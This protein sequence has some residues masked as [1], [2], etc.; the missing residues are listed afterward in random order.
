MISRFKRLSIATQA[1]YFLVTMLLGTMSA[2]Y[3]WAKDNAL[4]SE[5]S[6]SR[7]V[8]DMADAFRAQ[9]AKHG[10]F[11]V[12]RDSSEDIAKV[13]KYLASYEVE[14]T[15]IDG[16]KKN[17]MFHQKNP[18]L[19]LGD[20]SEEVQ[21][22]KA[23]AQ[24]RM[25]SDNF[26]NPKNKPDAFEESALAALRA[27]DGNSEYWGV[28]NGQ[29]RYTRALKAT[30]ACLTCHGDSSAAPSVVQAQYLP[31]SSGKVGGG[32][33]YQE[34]TIVGLT[35]VSVAHKTPLQMLAS[36]HLGFW[37]SAFFVVG[38]MAVA[39]ASIV[40]GLVRPLRLQSKYAESIAVSEDLQKI[41][42]P[43]FDSDEA[44]S[45]NE[46]HLQSHALKSLH[47]SMSAAMNYINGQRK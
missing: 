26:M 2:L 12:R 9:A 23:A 25:V 34:G 29:L 40:R 5:L 20:F 7:T 33:G 35:S 22:S 31:P 47:E 4:E 3:F 39:Y 18:F 28:V 15:Q 30:K 36:Q 1:L 14:S 41:H 24:F 37:L 11:Y 8:A 21:K 13:G 42:M 46:I 16:V 19:A 43:R 27:T 10:G 17:F 44:S 45:G 6:H 32:Y 38:L